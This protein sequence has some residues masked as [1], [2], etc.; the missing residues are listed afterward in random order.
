MSLRRKVAT[1]PQATEDSSSRPEMSDQMRQILTLPTEVVLGRKRY[2]AYNDNKYK[3]DASAAASEK[4]IK[5]FIQANGK[6]MTEAD[7]KKLFEYMK[8]NAGNLNTKTSKERAALFSTLFADYKRQMA[9]R[10]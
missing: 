7:K 5:D 10:V 8:K 3:A 1:A 6:T 9:S 2:K 4:M